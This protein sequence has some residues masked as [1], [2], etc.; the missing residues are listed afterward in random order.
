[1][2]W[3]RKVLWRTYGPVCINGTWWTRFNRELESLYN[4]P[5]IVA[6]IKSRKIEWPSHV[7]RMESSRVPQKNPGWQTW[8]EKKYWKTETKMAGWCCE[9]FKKYGSKA[10][11]KEGWR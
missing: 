7:L 6:E 11:E 4:R 2:S 9:W 10:M 3:E 8:G 5:Y 1:M